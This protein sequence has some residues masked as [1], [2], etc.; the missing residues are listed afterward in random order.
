[1]IGIYTY[2]EDCCYGYIEGIFKADSKDIEFIEKNHLTIYLSEALG[3]YSEID[4][5]FTPG[6]CELVSDNHNEVEILNKVTNFGYNPMQQEGFRFKNSDKL[7]E[8]RENFENEFCGNVEEFITYLKE[9][10]LYEGLEA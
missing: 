4:I 2:S 8:I 7:E 3:K 5:T 9:Q 1:M 10:N 6:M